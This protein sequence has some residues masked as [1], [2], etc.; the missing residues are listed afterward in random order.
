MTPL[1]EKKNAVLVVHPVPALRQMIKEVLRKNHFQSV[2]ALENCQDALAFCE[3]ETPSWIIMAP[4]MEDDVNC[5]SLLLTVLQKQ[6]LRQT[7][8]SIIFDKSKDLFCLPL[9]FELGLF[10]WHVDCTT[11]LL[12]ERELETLYSR[13]EAANHDPVLV[14]AEYIRDYLDRNM[15]SQSRVDLEKRLLDLYQGDSRLKVRLAEAYFL[16]HQPD[17]AKRVLKQAMF[18]DK[19]TTPV[20][21][22][23]VEKF[24]G[25]EDPLDS[26]EPAGP[27][28]GVENCFIIDS[29]R[30]ALNAAKALTDKLGIKNV[31]LFE[32]G[33]TAWEELKSS[34]ETPPQLIISEWRVRG[35][36]GSAFIQRMKD[37][38]LGDSTI[39]VTSSLI[40]QKELP[41]LEEIGVDHVVDKPVD[42]QSFSEHLIRTVRDNVY[43]RDSRAIERKVRKL[44][45]ANKVDQASFLLKSLMDDEETPPQIKQ[46]LQ[47]E[48]EFYQGNYEVAKN[49][50]YQC[51]EQYNDSPYFLNLLGKILM[52]IAAFKEALIC[53]EKAHKKCP[54]NIERISNMAVANIQLGWLDKALE[55][56]EEA[57][58]L[59]KDAAS[60]KEI[61]CRY[62]WEMGDEERA[63]TLFAQIDNSKAI[64]SYMNNRAISF[65]KA[66]RKEDGISLYQ[67]TLNIIPPERR[68]LF[69][70]VSYNLSL[71]YARTGQRQKALDQIRT[72]TVEDKELRLKLQSLKSRLTKSIE[73]NESLVFA[74]TLESADTHS[75]Q[76]DEDAFASLLNA[77]HLHS[78]EVCC[79]KIFYFQEESANRSRDLLVSAMSH[80]FLQMKKAG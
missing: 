60:V 40:T 22:E 35:V 8:T 63:R 54:Y 44:L 17:E 59:D 21:K 38:G 9:E 76:K 74:N 20:C 10:S 69:G 66:G 16:N 23:L 57:K 15:Y 78:G 27:N 3:I 71:A 43:P 2:I 77:L 39:F 42:E 47:S 64:I 65:V 19:K 5:T 51:L 24:L 52:K 73:K 79:C 48:V 1:L 62:A 4:M 61:E 25:L 67:R 72:I 45:W 14:S 50:A 80:S 55:F 7:R 31:K 33:A 41:L 68:D 49:L 56:I 46:L 30:H 13:I 12:F 53:L 34:K 11:S 29:D 6:H 37:M 75:Q 32:D 36:S 18:F 26:N 70:A 28:L 58:Q